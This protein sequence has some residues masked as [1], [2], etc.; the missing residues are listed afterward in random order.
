MNSVNIS[1]VI[2]AADE[3][4]RMSDMK[5]CVDRFVHE[6]ASNG[7]DGSLLSQ[8]DD[9]SVMLFKVTMPTLFGLIVFF[10]ILGNLLV[11]YV[12]LAKR[13]LRTITNLLLLN[14]ALADVSFLFFCGSFTVVNYALTE[15][16][17]GDVVCRIIQYLL[18]VTA[19]VN[20]YTLV[21]VSAVRY[22]SVVYG[23]SSRFLQ[24][25]RN[26][27]I[28]IISIWVVFIV[29]KIPIVIV[30]GI[31]CDE[32][33]DRIQCIISG[34][35][36]G[37]NLFAT[38]FVFAYALPLTFISTLYILILR[39]LRTK[40]NMTTPLS[41]NGEHR[42]RHVTKIVLLVVL[43]FA[44][45]WLPLHIHLLVAYYGQI[46]SSHVYKVLLILWHCLVY[47]NS[48]LNPI[49]YNVFSK[50]FRDAFRKT[51]CCVAPI[52]DV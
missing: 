51:I 52:D 28:V 47:A 48:L 24:Q 10:G 27:V 36:N 8:R 1:S 39:H 15:W 9:F 20:V 21:A 12:I 17:L 40:A 14:L 30:H 7:S 18:Y 31:S 2:V 42:R 50:D 13:K 38:F 44:V 45:S 25:K 6:G 11:I 3:E 37:Q 4:C 19:Y 43:V 49:I 26:I 22:V 34:K 33:S 23:A 29:A 41:T 5:P 16:P 32:T 46:P 35:I